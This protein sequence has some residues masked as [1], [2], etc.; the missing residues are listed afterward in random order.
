[1]RLKSQSCVP[2]ARCQRTRRYHRNITEICH[3]GN[4]H[5]FPCYT[6]KHADPLLITRELTVPRNQTWSY[7]NNF[8]ICASARSCQRK[9]P[10]QKDHTHCPPLT[11]LHGTTERTS[12]QSRACRGRRRGELVTCCQYS[13]RDGNAE[14]YPVSC[15]I[16]SSWKML[17]MGMTSI[18]LQ[19]MQPRSRKSGTGACQRERSLRCREAER[20]RI[21]ARM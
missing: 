4:L 2:H 16:W 15:T 20:Q 21:C 12:C 11:R 14:K 19:K 8:D 13:S 1:M 17:H 6:K 3:E 18:S 10:P 7:V 9:F 5:H